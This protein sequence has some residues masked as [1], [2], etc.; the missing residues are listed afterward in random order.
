MAENIG[1]RIDFTEFE[2][3]WGSRP[4]GYILF[5]AKAAAE[6]YYEEHWSSYPA[7]P[8]P[9]YYI[10]AERPRLV[11]FTAAETAKLGDRGSHHF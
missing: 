7:G 5:K 2:R 1:W 9:D 3:G 10:H 8:A 4:D 6:A 11:E